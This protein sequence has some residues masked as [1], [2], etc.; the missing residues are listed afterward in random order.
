MVS[1]P[2]DTTCDK[3]LIDFDECFERSADSSNIAERSSAA[4][5]NSNMH[6]HQACDLSS[7]LSTANN[8]T[9]NCSPELEIPSSAR[10][11]SSSPLQD[12]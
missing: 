6:H 10:A 5:P 2:S 12:L 9:H 4:T 8:K 3:H 1:N 11:T 7:N